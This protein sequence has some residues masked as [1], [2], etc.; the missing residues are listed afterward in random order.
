M[1][2]AH[3]IMIE[4]GSAR[5][6]MELT[7]KREKSGTSAFGRWLH[8]KDSTDKGKIRFTNFG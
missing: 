7:D 8:E 5:A 3:K 2:R 6:I 4:H 1:L